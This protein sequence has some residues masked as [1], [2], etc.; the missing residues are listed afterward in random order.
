[1]TDR[2]VDL[3]AERARRRPRV[4]TP[5]GGG[6]GEALSLMG[7]ASSAWLVGWVKLWMTI[8]VPRVPRVP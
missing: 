1:M 6:A 5:P 4:V 8:W 7:M 3:A 2:I